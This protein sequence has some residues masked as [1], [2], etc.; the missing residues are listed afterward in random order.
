M[1]G[2][3]DCAPVLSLSRLMTAALP[4]AAAHPMAA[5]GGRAAARLLRRPREALARKGLDGPRT[6][7][8]YARTRADLFYLDRLIDATEGPPDPPRRAVYVSA[9]VGNWELGAAWLAR[10]H[11]LTVLA[12]RP[13]TAFARFVDAR[14][15]RYRIRTVHTDRPGAGLRAMLCADGPVAALIDRPAHRIPVAPLAA[16]WI[17]RIPL[18]PMWAV[19]TRGARYRI[20]MD[21]PIEP[22]EGAG[23]SREEGIARLAERAAGALE[24]VRARHADQWFAFSDDP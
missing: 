23:E 1:Y 24:R 21:E 5:A 11:G 18:M 3:L 13:R 22:R 15:D 2:W 10:R 20:E 17:R 4:R 19:M 9:H 14:R 16:A 6:M 8:N 7:A 12:G